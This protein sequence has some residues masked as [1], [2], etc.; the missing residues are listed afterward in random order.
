MTTAEHMRVLVLIKSLGPGGAERLVEEFARGSR[1]LSIDV[2]VVS[3]LDQ[4][5]H[6]IPNIE[7][8]GVPVRCLGVTRLRDLRWVTGLVHEVRRMRPHVI[9]VHSPALAPFVRVAARLGVFGRRRP[10]VVYTEHNE[11]SV[12]RWQ[13]RWA[14]ALTQRLDDTTIT[15]SDGVR[16]S[17]RPA[18]L[19]RRAIT[20]R[21]GINVA[22][23]RIN[24]GERDRLRR[25]LGISDDEVVV[26]TV[27][28]FRPV[29][30]YPML[31]RAC[32]I[33][34]QQVEHLRF[35]VVGQGPGAPEVHA[36]HD[37]LELGDRMLLLG[38]RP[39]ATTVMAASDVFTLS[40]HAEGL[41]VALMEALALGLPV[42]ATD[43]GGIAE[44]IDE[45]SGVLVPAGDA[46]ALARALIAV[47]TDR[48]HLARL[49]AGA[50]L[51]GDRFDAR[52]SME[53]LAAIYATV[54]PDA[55]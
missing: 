33:A 26:V 1:A 34:T 16:D 53:Q 9:H 27:A 14:N 52:H 18:A 19:R 10:A 40:S 8:A 21:H 48:Q 44:T 38:Y 37:A 49:Q 2:E 13:T 55:T 39:D 36:L 5:R 23:V 32:K 15:V 35:V 30:N 46:E 50:R 24:T 17:I 29:K 43:V 6:L 45:S 31:L 3:L 11:W 22:D 47:S 54:A 20:I 25:E 4:K 51:L 28:N 7:A 12:Y 41:P 42:V